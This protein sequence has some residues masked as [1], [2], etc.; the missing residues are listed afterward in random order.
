LELA[1]AALPW[2]LLEAKSGGNSLVGWRHGKREADYL[3]ELHVAYKTLKHPE[4]G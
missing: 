4:I 1:A 2:N 3:R